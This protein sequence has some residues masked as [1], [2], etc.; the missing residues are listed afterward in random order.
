MVENDKADIDFNYLLE[1][2]AITINQ[3]YLTNIDGTPL[4]IKVSNIEFANLMIKSPL[5]TGKTE[6]LIYIMDNY[7]KDKNILMVSPRITFS[8]SVSQ[9]LGFANYKNIEHTIEFSE[10]QRWVVVQ[11]D[12]LPR[13]KDKNNIDLIIFDELL[14]TFGHATRQNKI[15]KLLVNLLESNAR[16]I[17]LDANLTYFDYK[18]F[19]EYTNHEKIDVYINSFKTQSDIINIY[20]IEQNSKDNKIEIYTAI[21]DKLVA[22][23]RVVVSITQKSYAEEIKN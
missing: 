9:W 6:L 12:S 14:T 1:D 21:K 19:E 22:N 2:H 4:N 15:P 5:G 17:V 8:D 11:V 7:F 16:K 18:L 3:R 20:P 10:T 23:K 13:I